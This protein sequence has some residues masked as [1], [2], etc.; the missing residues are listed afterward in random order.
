MQRVRALG[1]LDLTVSIPMNALTGFAGSCKNFHAGV[2]CL[3][4]LRKA[5]GLGLIPRAQNRRQKC[6]NG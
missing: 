4:W 5:T 1:R 6:I 2:A 3:R